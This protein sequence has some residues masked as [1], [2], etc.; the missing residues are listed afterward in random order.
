MCEYIP[1]KQKYYAPDRFDYLNEAH[2][3][4]GWSDSAISKLWL[5]NLHY[6]DDLRSKAKGTRLNDQL[7]LINRWIHENPQGIDIGWEPFPIS[8]RIVNWIIW[9]MEHGLFDEKEL[10]SLALQTEY[11]MHHM[12]YHLLG[13]HLIKNAKALIFAGLYFESTIAKKWLTMGLRLWN[14]ELREQVLSD[15]GHF[16]RS[17]MYHALVL[18]DLLEVISFSDSGNRIE[19]DQICEWRE[20]ANR[21]LVALGVMV[22]P[23]RE[24]AFFNDAARGI[25]PEPDK[26]FA[27]G[28][29]LGIE[30][31][32]NQCALKDLPE[33]GYARLQ[34]G[35]WTLL[36]DA[37]PVG[38]DYLPGHAHA[39]TLSFELSLG[40][41]RVLVNSGTSCYGLCHDRQRQRQTPAHN[42]LTVDNHDSS[43]V[44]AGF[45]VA[46]RAKIVERD[47]ILEKDYIKF[48]AAHDGYC[49]IAG[50]GLHRRTWSLDEN[51][52]E[53][54]DYVEGSAKH[55]V[56]VF[57]R[58]APEV[59]ISQLSEFVYSLMINSSRKNLE[60]TVSHQMAWTVEE[61]TYHPEFG[62]SVFA[63]LLRGVITTQLPFELTTVLRQKK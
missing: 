23:D 46:C 32:Q 12:E 39:D 43:E 47:Y 45:R 52:V 24:I 1:V 21:M 56:Q 20:V 7:D 58:F 63:P 26:L 54:R 62:T 10:A 50:V 53:I 34:W 25:A 9:D 11:L 55:L 49:R 40:G 31:H 27:L 35:E 4:R 15:G 19:S 42:A 51:G 18:E 13:N 29:M 59:K 3:C 2:R 60:I 48:N 36:V 22:H 33:T 30:T 28:K 57:F 61:T 38:P 37:A 16:E 5:Y 6:F 41:T 17:T 14:R 8:L 44:W